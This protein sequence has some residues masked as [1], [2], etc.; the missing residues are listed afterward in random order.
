VHQVL[1]NKTSFIGLHNKGIVYM[2]DFNDPYGILCLNGIQLESN[3]SIIKYILRCNVQH[4]AACSTYFSLFNDLDLILS[5]E[6]PF[7]FMSEILLNY[8]SSN[9]F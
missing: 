3:I 6:D 2:L 7:D 9:Y 1:W 8:N 5:K 4:A